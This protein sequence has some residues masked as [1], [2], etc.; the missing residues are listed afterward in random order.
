MSSN[1]KEWY[2]HVISTEQIQTHVRQVIIG[3]LLGLSIIAPKKAD[4]N[5]KFNQSTIHADNLLF[6]FFILEPSKLKRSPRL[7]KYFD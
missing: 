1:E 6:I 2:L 3:A 5:L 4:I 7:S